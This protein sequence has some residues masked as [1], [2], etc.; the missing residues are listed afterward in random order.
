MI[1]TC[2]NCGN[3][4]WDKKIEG[5]IIT[6]PICGNSWKFL[7]K[8]IFVLTGCS[9]VGK[10]TCGSI[11]QRMTNDYVVLDAD[12]FYNIMPHQSDEDYFDQ[13][14]QMYSLSKN[15]SQCGRSVVWTMAGNI[16]KLNKAYNLSFFTMIYVLALTCSPEALKDRMMNG[17]GI[18]D[19]EWIKGSVGYNQY[20]MSHNSIGEV[21]YDTLDI[22]DKS[23]EEVAKSILV[24]LQTKS[25]DEK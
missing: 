15:I 7:K 14:E 24:W 4:Q 3:H 19:E 5:D 2:S 23:P 11:L 6:C 13:L 18:S 16:D 8:P 17:R 1:G 25:K 10:T 12:M 22:T 9:G 21:K 20:F